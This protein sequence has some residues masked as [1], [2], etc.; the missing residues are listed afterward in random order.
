MKK[1]TFPK[2]EAD[3]Q[4]QLLGNLKSQMDY[5]GFSEISDTGSCTPRPGKAIL[6]IF[7]RSEASTRFIMPLYVFHLLNGTVDEI[8]VWNFAS[9]GTDRAYIDSL[10]GLA[11]ETGM[12]APKFQIMTPE[13]SGN[14][15]PY[16]TAVYLHYAKTL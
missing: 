7:A 8:H 14:D 15:N 5:M 16:L 12:P 3:I 1:H 10:R 9:K 6:S 4:E 13:S 11:D 2:T